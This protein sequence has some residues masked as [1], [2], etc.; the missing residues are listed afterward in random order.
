MRPAD[1]L[2]DA[3]YTELLAIYEL[4]RHVFSACFAVGSLRKL[5]SRHGINPDL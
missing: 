2:S 3:A 5:A 4:D 1:C